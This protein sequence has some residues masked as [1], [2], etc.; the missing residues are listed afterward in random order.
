M[1]RALREKGD[2]KAIDERADA[3]DTIEWLLKDVPNNNRRVGMLGVSYDGWLTGDAR[4]PSGAEGGLPS[5]LKLG[6]YS[7]DISSTK[8]NNSIGV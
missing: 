8:S 4:C 7:L 6:V 3:Y 2:P 1:Q 5:S